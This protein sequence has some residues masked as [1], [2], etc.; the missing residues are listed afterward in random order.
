MSVRTVQSLMDTANA[1]VQ[2]SAE[3]A[4]SIKPMIEQCEKDMEAK[5]SKNFDEIT[6]GE[7]MG[8]KW[9][10]HLADVTMG[11]FSGDLEE[12][13]DQL[14]EMDD[15]LIAV[16]SYV[17]EMNKVVDMFGGMT[18]DGNPVVLMKVDDLMKILVSCPSF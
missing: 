1:L 7:I 3:I 11:A 14:D 13:Q 8:A 2:R 15:L 16:E 5:I 18:P 17:D 6:E 10:A 9:T 12:F 4:F